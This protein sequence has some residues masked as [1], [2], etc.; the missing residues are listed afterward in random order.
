MARHEK[1]AAVSSRRENAP[2]DQPQ[3]IDGGMVR[4]LRMEL[5]RRV[6]DVP[7][8][9]R[10]QKADLTEQGWIVCISRRWSPIEI[11][12]EYVGLYWYT[13]PILGPSDLRWGF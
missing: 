12:P 5:V 2:L 10:G 9:R 11:L 1:S 3:G 8:V 6:L 13:R 7:E 4:Q